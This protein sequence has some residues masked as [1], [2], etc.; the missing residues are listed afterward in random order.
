MGMMKIKDVCLKIGSG[1]TP[2]GGKDV[3]VDSGIAL[4]R[5]QNVLDYT[6]SFDGLAHINEEQADKLSNVVVQSGDVLLNITGDS[7]ARACIVRDDALPARV[8]QHVCIIR[9]DPHYLLN[10]YLLYCLQLAK[11][12]LLK[13]SSGG[14][15]RN[16]L[17]KSMIGELEIDVPS[18]AKQRKITS[19][20]DSFQQKIDTNNKINDNLAA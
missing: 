14:A 5:S 18:V 2:R 11:R 13:L 12:Q 9:P 15:T 20:L 6:F 16:A 8:N 3:Y 4:I 10:S 1:A 7:V 19:L 17:T